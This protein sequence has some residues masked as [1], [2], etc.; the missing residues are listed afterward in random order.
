MN[1]V[2]PRLA[3]LDLDTRRMSRQSLQA[4]LWSPSSFSLSA[5]DPHRG[6]C[7]GN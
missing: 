2:E 6:Y 4:C 1:E 7:G 5:Q 3:I